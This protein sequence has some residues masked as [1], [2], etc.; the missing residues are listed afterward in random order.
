MLLYASER[1]QYDDLIAQQVPPLSQYNK[2]Q[3]SE[4]RLNIIERGLKSY[5]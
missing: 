3:H 2:I 4:L 5:N 1:Q